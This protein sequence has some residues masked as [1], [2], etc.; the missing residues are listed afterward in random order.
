MSSHTFVVDKG[1]SGVR[2][3]MS[4]LVANMLESLLQMWKLHAPA[5]H[6]SRTSLFVLANCKN[7]FPSVFCI[8]S[9]DCRSS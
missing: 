7:Y 9:K 5:E 6:V 8:S 3:G 1:C 4:Q 2:V